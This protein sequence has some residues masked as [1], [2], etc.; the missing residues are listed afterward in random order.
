VE[1]AKEVTYLDSC[2]VV[3]LFGG[4]T[5]KLSKAAAAGIREADEILVSP[6]LVLGHALE[7]SWIRDPFDRLIIAQ[8]NANEAALVTKDAEIRGHYKRSIW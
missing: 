7:Q 8:A 5:H 3:G 1:R 4:A 2:V 6:A